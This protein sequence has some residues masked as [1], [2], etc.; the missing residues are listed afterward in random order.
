MTLEMSFKNYL[1]FYFLNLLDFDTWPL[2]CSKKAIKCRFIIKM[3]ECAARIQ[4]SVDLEHNI[5]MLRYV[6]ITTYGYKDTSNIKI[7]FQP[8][9]QLICENKLLMKSMRHCHKI[10]GY[11]LL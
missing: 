6:C 1:E 11:Q 4:D 9:K 2:I 10:M 5:T 3:E 8:Y 7:Y